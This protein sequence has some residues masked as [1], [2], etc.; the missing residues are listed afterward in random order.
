MLVSHILN[1][2]GRDVL[3]I[4]AYATLHEAAQILSANRIGAL[5]VLTRDG[6]FEGLISERDIVRA[7]AEHGDVALGLAVAASMVKDIAVCEETD[8]IEE[9]MDTMTCCRFRH[10]PVVK[11]DVVV[12]IV[13][14]GDVV[15]T[16]I[17]EAMRESQA[18]K[19]YI[20]AG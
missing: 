7:L 11:D 1:D 12:G 14:I 6:G 5:V 18:L 4:P 10:L 3:A 8:T 20:A 2:K 15:K 9:I 17:A 16:R 19:Q 13:S